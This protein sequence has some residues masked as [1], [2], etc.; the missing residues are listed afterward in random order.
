MSYLS[1]FTSIGTLL[2]CA[3]PS[4]MVML[5]LGATLATIVSDFPW[6]AALSHHKNQVF[7]VAGSLIA[8]NIGYFCALAPRIRARARACDPQNPTACVIASRASRAVLWCSVVLYLA[9]FFSAYLLGPILI[10]AG[11]W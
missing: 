9:G 5:G 4:L 2:C 1:L 8:V 6:L 7:A 3:L 10:K 11:L